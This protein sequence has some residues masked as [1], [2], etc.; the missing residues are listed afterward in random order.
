MALL[1]ESCGHWARMIAREFHS[2]PATVDVRS[3]HSLAS[4]EIFQYFR[5][6]G[7]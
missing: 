1:G 4:G 7:R 5:T 6:F 3:A 2:L